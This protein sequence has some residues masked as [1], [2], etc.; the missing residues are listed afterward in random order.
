MKNLVIVSF[1]SKPDTLD[2]LK[3]SMKIALPD[4]RAFDGCISV[5]TFIEESTNTIHLIEDWESLEHQSK[6]LNWRIE[7]G[8]LNDLDPL[9]D[10]GAASVRI[11]LCG[12]EHIDI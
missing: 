1:P 7:T 6:Y 5:S 11:K 12:A 3:E 2:K 10:G 8:L 9:L 4:T